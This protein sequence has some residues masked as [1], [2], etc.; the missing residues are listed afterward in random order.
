MRQ[1]IWLSAA[2][3]RSL[4]RAYPELSD[5][6]ASGKAIDHQAAA[7]AILTDEEDPPDD[8][9]VIELLS[10]ALQR[11]PSEIGESDHGHFWPGAIVF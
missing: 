4:A 5:W 1:Q 8:V 11:P 10:V 3:R 9:T 6:I 7:M 2:S